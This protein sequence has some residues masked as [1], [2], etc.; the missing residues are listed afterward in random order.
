MKKSVL[1]SSLYL[2]V[3]VLL[4]ACFIPEKFNAFVEVAPDASYDYRYSG[5]AVFALAAAEIKQTGALSP[6]ID[7]DLK[8]QAKAMTKDKSFRSAKYI[9]SGRYE[10]VIEGKKKP[11]ESLSLLEI[12]SVQKDKDGIITISSPELKDKKLSE[13]ASL[14][15]KIDGTLDIKL[16]KNVEIISQNATS[17]PSFFGMF[18]AYSWKIGKADQRPIMKFRLKS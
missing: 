3:A 9:G 17:T 10:L 4:T 8:A 15:I 14:G 13:I 5:T 1:A 12:L 2:S 7:E 11:G 16:P 18:G 6:K